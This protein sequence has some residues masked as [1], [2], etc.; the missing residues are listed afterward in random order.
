MLCGWVRFAAAG[1]SHGASIVSDLDL[2]L[3][4]DVR[5]CCHVPD[6]MY[7]GGGPLEHCISVCAEGHRVCRAVPDA[8]RLTS[9][10]VRLK[11]IG[12]MQNQI[13]TQ[14]VPVLGRARSSCHSLHAVCLWVRSPPCALLHI[15]WAASRHARRSRHMSALADVEGSDM[16]LH[17]IASLVGRL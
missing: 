16:R 4:L 5:A 2:G 1:L 13:E 6:W 7:T 15:I 8:R 11:R 9:G 12:R 14:E 3:D 17:S 10:H